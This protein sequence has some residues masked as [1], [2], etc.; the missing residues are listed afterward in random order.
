MPA[1]RL[2]A[3]SRNSGTRSSLRGICLLLCLSSGIGARLRCIGVKS[4]RNPR[5][6]EASRTM[7]LPAHERRY[8]GLASLSPRFRASLSPSSCP[9]FPWHHVFLSF[10]PKTWMAGTSPGHD[11]NGERCPRRAKAPADRCFS[12]HDQDKSAPTR[13]L[14]AQAPSGNCVRRRHRRHPLLRRPLRRRFQ[15][16]PGEHVGGCAGRRHFAGRDHPRRSPA[17]PRTRRC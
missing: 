2:I 1:A 15:L 5:G 3:S 11:E 16:L 14:H 10:G 4:I 12:W 9:G 8:G 13:D 7:R 6:V 17:S